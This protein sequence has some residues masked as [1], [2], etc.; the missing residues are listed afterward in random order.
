LLLLLLLLG[1]LTRLNLTSS[2]S[3]RG[4]NGSG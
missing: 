4:L 2:S 1:P 3:S